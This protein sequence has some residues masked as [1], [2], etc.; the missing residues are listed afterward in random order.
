MFTQLLQYN[1]VGLLL[2]RIAIAIIFLYHG[3]PKL[4]KSKIMSQMMGM[5]AGMI[6]MLGIVESLASLGVAFGVY[7]QLSALVLAIVM[8]GAMGMKMMKWGVPFAAMDKTGWE[9]DF[10]LFFASVAIL[11]GGGGSIG[12]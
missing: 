4:T 11:L 12:L 10:I 2:L 9:F 8:V 5:P 7:T 6:V 1:D 3:L